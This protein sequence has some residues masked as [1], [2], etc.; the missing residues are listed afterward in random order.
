M[1]HHHLV[2]AAPKRA[3]AF[4]VRKTALAVSGI[5]RHAMLDTLG[6]QLSLSVTVDGTLGN[7]DCHFNCN[8]CNFAHL[9]ILLFH[10]DAGAQVFDTVTVADSAVLLPFQDGAAANCRWANIKFA[11]V[12]LFCTCHPPASWQH[13]PFHQV[14]HQ[15]ST[16]LLQH[17]CC[18][19]HAYCCTTFLGP[20]DLRAMAA[21]EFQR[22]LSITV[23]D[24]PVDLLS[25]MF[26][27]TSSRMDCTT[28]VSKI[29][30]KIIML[31]TPSIL[32]CLFN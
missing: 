2:D 29:N 18:L 26:N 22:I 28:L 9:S 1:P 27:L 19:N 13:H 3:H 7:W 14:L 16:G 20:G 15:A 21:K 6:A 30:S 17:D 24:G 32:E 4:Q 23:Q 5:N 31:A 8:C 11:H 25:P 12:Q 10:N